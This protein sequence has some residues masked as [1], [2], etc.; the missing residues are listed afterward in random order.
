[1][2]Q[3]FVPAARAHIEE[4]GRLLPP[5]EAP[6]RDDGLLHRALSARQRNRAANIEALG[7]IGAQLPQQIDGSLVLD[8]STPR[9]SSPDRTAWRSRGCSERPG[10]RRRLARSGHLSRWRGIRIGST[11][12]EEGRTKAM[13]R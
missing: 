7:V 13:L 10:P 9:R 1:M 3:A 2:A 5:T 11:D 8:T 4:P 6:D 12:H